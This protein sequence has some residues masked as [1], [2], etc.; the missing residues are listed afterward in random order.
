MN[1]EA[2]ILSYQGRPDDARELLKE[3]LRVWR[4]AGYRVGIAVATSDVGL[5]AAR[6]GRF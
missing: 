4:L 3:A 6:A 2:E 1:N 5:A